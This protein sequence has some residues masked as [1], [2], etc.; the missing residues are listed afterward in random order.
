MMKTIR[1][2][3]SGVQNGNM[4]SILV[5]PFKPGPGLVGDLE[6]LAARLSEKPAMD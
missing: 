5:S 6:K 3:V 1:R 2:F 4:G